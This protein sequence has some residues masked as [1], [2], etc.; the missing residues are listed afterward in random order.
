[1]YQSWLS[2][3]EHPATSSGDRRERN[4]TH[5]L[6]RRDIEST[7]PN[8]SR[9]EDEHVDACADDVVRRAR[10]LKVR[11]ASCQGV[12]SMNVTAVG[13]PQGDG[14]LARPLGTASQPLGSRKDL[15][16]KGSLPRLTSVKSPNV[17][18]QVKHSGRVG[19]V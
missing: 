11:V 17:G 12:A 2:L 6:P 5:Q 3:P 7:T 9:G 10:L 16:D 1:M 18:Y 13:G 15:P 4:Y 19:G 8:V 14:A